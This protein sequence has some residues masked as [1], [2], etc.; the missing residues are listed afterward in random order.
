[1]KS[2]SLRPMD[3][4]GP[5]SLSQ[6]PSEDSYEAPTSSERVDRLPS[7]SAMPP[8]T[9]APEA[10]R[11]WPLGAWGPVGAISAFLIAYGVTHAVVILF[12][13]MLP[14]GKDARLVG[15]L[16]FGEM[17]FA[18][19]VL[20]WLK[21]VAKAP[22]STLALRLPSLRD[23]LVGILSGVALYFAAGWIFHRVYRIAE[24]V[25]GHSPSSGSPWV[26]LPKGWFLALVPLIVVVGP[27]AEEMLFRGAIYQGMRRRYP[28]I[29]AMFL[30]AIPFAFIHVLPVRLPDALFGGMALAFIYEKRRNLATSMVAHGTL[31][32][33]MIWTYFRVRY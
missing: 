33:I 27:F 2:A 26:F 8:P 31:N 24:L 18:A 32:A 28:L 16:W 6:S 13:Y 25:L 21:F 12:D 5:S 9:A 10:T 7:P 17:G 11:T 1:M 4:T 15:M 23:I 19:G 3:P 14:V 22:F 20:F 29:A 30:A